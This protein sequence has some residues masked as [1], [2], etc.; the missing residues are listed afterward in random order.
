MR[1]LALLLIT[2]LMLL[3]A[4]TAV[5]AQGT[6]VGTAASN[7]NLTT[8]VE[9]LNAADASLVNVLS[10]PGPY[11]VFAPSNV[12][13]DNFESYLQE[14]FNMGVADVMADQELLT[15]LLSYHV[16]AGNVFSSQLT[17]GQVIPTLYPATGI[18][19]IINA[20]GSVSLN[21]GVATVTSADNAAGNGVVHVISNVLFNGTLRDALQ[22]RSEVVAQE[23]LVARLGNS[24]A[25]VI[26]QSPDHGMFFSVLEA[27]GLDVVLTNGFPFT[28]FAPT[29]AAFTH[30]LD[31]L[32]LTIDAV[33]AQPEILDTI[34]RYHIVSA[35][36]DDAALF[37]ADGGA[38]PTILNEQLVGDGEP[39]YVDVVLR[40]TG[41]VT[42]NGDV[43][44]T[45]AAMEAD[46]GYVYSVDA[47][48]VPNEIRSL[49]GLPL[50]E[51]PAME[52]AA[53]EEP[54]EETAEEPVEEVVDYGNSIAGI[55]QNNP[56]FSILFQILEATGNTDLLA[57]GFPFTVFAPTD[58]AFQELLD[59][60]GIP[61]EVAITQTELLDSVLRYHII[62]DEVTGEELAGL[63]SVGT[64]LNESLPGDGDAISVTVSDG[65]VIL[66]D[67]VNVVE[68]DIEASNGIVHVVDAVLL[69]A[70]VAAA[71]GLQ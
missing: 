44:V 40:T 34:L 67:S 49:L 56:D 3:L 47:I 27:S 41:G 62:S 20:D 32:G 31:A 70:E 21:N 52:E 65:A 12:A 54:A 16:V 18:G 64:I 30:L 14:N 61:V 53:A 38:I 23:A 71:L 24:I 48:I 66:N 55:A 10:G 28:V 7:A 1:K 68:A 9:A 42:I 43:N 37:D 2:V 8:F 19:V 36:I 59:T 5:S 6:V 29:D 33:L 22:A 46:N 45:S 50:Y 35:E 17:D 39:I 58:A 57:T 25:G 63:D 4:M 60:L 15:N 13:F 51:P 26:A 11:T 69:P